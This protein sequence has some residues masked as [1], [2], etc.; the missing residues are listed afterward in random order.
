MK[1]NDYMKKKPLKKKF[2]WRTDEH[3][4]VTLEIENK[5]FFKR[6]LGLPLVSMVCLDELGSFVWQQI[7][8]NINIEEIG[9]RVEERFG[10]RSNPVYE[11]LMKYFKILRS[12][13][14]IDW[15]R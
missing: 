15:N 7:D 4:V 9:R 2:K 5:G 14:F 13:H 6:I 1:R 12:Y 8:G 3:G 10:E 11:R